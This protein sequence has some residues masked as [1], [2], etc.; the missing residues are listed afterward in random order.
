MTVL[1]GTLMQGRLE[2][3]AARV[4]GWKFY[5]LLSWMTFTFSRLMGQ[6][7][8]Q[9]VRWRELP[10]CALRCWSIGSLERLKLCWLS[11]AK[12]Q[13]LQQCTSHALKER[14]TF[15]SRASRGT[16]CVSCRTT[17]ISDCCNEIV[18]DAPRSYQTFQS[19][20]SCVHA[21]CAHSFWEPMDCEVRQTNAGGFP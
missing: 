11:G 6:R 7:S 18:L 14:R 10:N 3:H 4:S 20:H 21:T 17:N 12:E 16:V 13:Q 19:G 9:H 15:H 8:K 5:Q 2:H 1:S